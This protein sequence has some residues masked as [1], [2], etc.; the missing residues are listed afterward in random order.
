MSL[1]I[2][3]FLSGDNHAR[4]ESSDSGL[5]LSSN[6]FA[7]NTDFINHMDTSMDCISGKQEINFQYKR[8]EILIQF[9]NFYYFNVENG[10]IIDNL[11]TTLQVS[12]LY[13]ILC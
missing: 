4:Q 9:Y 11:D 13:N 1:H 12:F 2:D 7:V 10:S 8:I 5:S 6:S 3:P